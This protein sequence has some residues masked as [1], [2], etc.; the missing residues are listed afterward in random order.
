METIANS[1]FF[2][3][4][5]EERKDAFSL[6]AAI[7]RSLPRD[8]FRLSL[9]QGKVKLEG[10]SE[11]ALLQGMGLLDAVVPSG[12]IADYLGD[13]QAECSCRWLYPM[14]DYDEEALCRRLLQLGYNGVIV[15]HIPSNIQIFKELDIQI[16][17]TVDTPE[18]TP[19]DN[20]WD[21]GLE[22][23]EGVDAVYWKGSYGSERYLHHPNARDDLMIDLA[24]R[25]VQALEEAIKGR[26]GLVYELDPVAPIH[27]VPELMDAVGEKTMISF[28]AL[29]GSPTEDHLDHHPLWKLLRELPDTSAT[30]LL[31]IL[32]SGGVCQGEGLWPVVPLEMIDY[33]KIHMRRQPFGGAVVMTRYLSQ[34]GTFLDAALWTSGHSLWGGYP[35]R[36]LLETWCKTYHP[37]LVSLELLG[38]IW[39]VSRRLS[40]LKAVGARPTE[41]CRM[42]SE[43][44]IGELNR[45]Q[46]EADRCEGD[47]CDYYTYFARDARRIVLH[48]LQTHHA[49]MV[50]V[51]NGDDLEASF[52]TA[53]QQGSGSGLGTGAKVSV[54][55][56]PQKGDAGTP[57]RRIYEDVTMTL[58]NRAR[59]AE[60]PKG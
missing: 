6:D 2:Q 50:N 51:L 42:L 43:S 28:S 18:A 40:G 55:H 56:E 22:D 34:P 12:H 5:F 26:C 57:M 25:E 8:Y 31:P 16:V 46:G 45:L 20:E 60:L 19:L 27:W 1:Q 17:L 47:I 49:P 9:D 29:N 36:L 54:L 15:D 52:W 39:K 24:M 53:I 44:L 14:G 10:G 38:D 33:A 11:S 58:G 21:P 7:I 37:S 48:F 32:N 13:H 3:I 35:P 4:A 59:L 30:R 41:E 23:L